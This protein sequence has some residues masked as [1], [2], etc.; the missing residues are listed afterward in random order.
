M[1]R[2]SLNQSKLGLSSAVLVTM[3]DASSSE[4]TILV[5][6]SIGQRPE[7]RGRASV[8]KSLGI[9][10]GKVIFFGFGGIIFAVGLTLGILW[11]FMFN[12]LLSKQLQ[13][14]RTSK[15]ADMWK[16]TPIPIYMEVHLFH[17]TN[18]EQSVRGPEKPVF[19]EKG[20]YVFKEHRS[21]VNLTWNDNS[22]I[23]FLNKKQW[24][25]MEDMSNGSLSDSITNLNVVA[26]IIGS[27]C[28]N[29]NNFAKTA[30]SVVMELEERQMYVTHTVEEWLFKGCNDSILNIVDKLKRWIKNPLP[31]D[32]FGW[33]YKKNMSDT[34]DGVY[35]MYTGVDDIDQLALLSSWNY[36]TQ[37][38][39]FPG[40]CGRVQGTMGELL[41]PNSADESEIKIFANDLCSVINLKAGDKE[42]VKN[43]TGVKF[44]AGEDVFSNTTACYCPSGKC[45]LSGV[46]DISTC[47]GAPAFVSFP[48]FYLADPSYRDAVVG[49]TPDPEKHSFRMTLEKVT[50]TPLD[51][52]ASL[53]INILMESIPGISFYKGLKR[54]HVPMIWFSEMAKISEPMANEL[55][56][57]SVLSQWGPVALF[58]IAGVGGVLVL[59]GLIL[60]SKG[61][62]SYESDERLLDH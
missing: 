4:Q 42:V 16:E 35:N 44:V 5:S 15:T 23:T 17:W 61:F 36:K 20:P 31:F 60:K 6:E 3:I 33:F 52:K 25:F 1:N 13:L 26:M 47:K 40:E 57:L 10:C 55:M 43:L 53:Q 32:K 27:R 24:I 38:G 39:G 21:K 56:P 62:C 18:P 51:V 49:M 28:K 48:H 34:A 46:R 45:P 14:T 50:A 11:P 12:S 58:L 59:I 29:L 37:T 54:V 7:I 41:P 2:C 30:V 19:V 22:T 8:G 9:C